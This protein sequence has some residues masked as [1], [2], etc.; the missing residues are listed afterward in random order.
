MA[1]KKPIVVC[2]NSVKGGT[3]K[4]TLSLLYL[5]KFYRDRMV[6]RNEKISDPESVDQTIS[7]VRVC[8]VDADVIG[9]GARHII[10]DQKKDLKN[11]FFNETTKEYKKVLHKIELLPKERKEVNE[12][13]GDGMYCVLLSDRPEDK[14]KYISDHRANPCNVNKNLLQNC[15]KKLL[16]HLIDSESFDLIVIDCS[17]GYDELPNRIY[18]HLVNCANKG[19]LLRPP[20]NLLL[21]TTEHSHVVCTL[22]QYR[23]LIGTSSMQ[24]H[25]YLVIN[26]L[27]NTLHLPD[28]EKNFC[29]RVK[30]GYK[31][32]VNTLENCNV[33]KMPKLQSSYSTDVQIIC[34]HY[35][36]FSENT[37]YN[38]ITQL[39]GTAAWQDL[40]V[41]D[42]CGSFADHLLKVPD[43]GESI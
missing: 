30:S 13:A 14:E 12:I 33:A 19:K 21:T 2:V 20:Y 6:A 32:L 11:G 10:F 7:T 41:E 22:Q 8:Y 39:D 28:I 38:S 25:L 40:Y 35:T 29:D 31:S 15:F 24:Y 34:E 26:D 23:Y 42:G 18:E 17:P 4:T 37:E 16:D 36:K 3:G 43:S 27:K 9:T 5:V 1:I